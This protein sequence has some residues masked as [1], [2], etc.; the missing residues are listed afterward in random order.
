M[1]DLAGPFL[2]ETGYH[3][4]ARAIHLSLNV[5]R[6]IDYSRDAGITLIEGSWEA[7]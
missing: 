1:R 4:Y 5:A 3:F 2:A 6:L 7:V